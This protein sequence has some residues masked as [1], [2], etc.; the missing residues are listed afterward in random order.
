M[1]MLL[2]LLILC[3]WVN[4]SPIWWKEAYLI[5]MNDVFSVALNSFCH[6]FIENFASMCF[7]GDWFVKFF[8]ASLSHFSIQ[9]KLLSWELQVCFKYGRGF[10]LYYSLE[11]ICDIVT[12]KTCS[13][14]AKS[15]NKRLLSNIHLGYL[16]YI[17][18]ED[19]V[20]HKVR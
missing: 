16:L 11:H 7:S 14:I 5:I 20:S 3:V 13:Q 4:T 17:L 10:L 19:K 1:Y 18:N 15:I 2:H 9:A 6:Y 12:L 8:V